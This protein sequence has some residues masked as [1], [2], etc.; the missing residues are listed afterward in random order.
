M[1]FPVLSSAT[2]ANALPPVP[3]PVQI[4]LLRHA[5]GSA[6]LLALLLPAS[7]AGAQA[8][9]APV[10]MVAETETLDGETLDI[11]GPRDATSNPHSLRAWVGQG[12]VRVALRVSDR[13]R[14]FAEDRTF[15]AAVP[16]EFEKLLA[17]ELNEAR[18]LLYTLT[19]D[20]LYEED[21]SDPS[22]PAEVDSLVFANEVPG[23][24]ATERVGDVKFWA[25]SDPADDRVFVVTT[26]RILVIREQ[27]G[28]LSFQ[29]AADELSST[30]RFVATDPADPINE[31]EVH[32]LER[33]RIV[34]DPGGT[35]YALVTADALGYRN[36]LPRPQPLVMLACDLDRAGGY[37]EPTFDRDPGVAKEFVYWNPLEDHPD[38]IDISK[39][40]ARA[41]MLYNLDTFV[42][43][44]GAY[45]LGACGVAQQVHLLRVT[46]AFTNGI[47][48]ISQVTLDD[49]R[50]VINVLAH[51]SDPRRFYGLS[52]HHMYAFKSGMPPVLGQTRGGN[53]GRGSFRDMAF[54]ELPGGRET[55]WTV[56]SDG[57]DSIGKVID[58]SE[59]V[60]PLPVADRFFGLY[61]CDGAVALPPDDVF[62]PTF[63]GVVRYSRQADDSF[64][65][66]P[67]SFSPA[68]VAG[69][70]KGRITEH[71]DIG[72]VAGVTRLFCATGRGDL[73]EFQLGANGNPRPA[74]SYVPDASLF[75]PPWAYSLTSANFSNDVVFLDLPPHGAYV[76]LDVSDA[77]VGNKA[78]ALVAFRWE[79][80]GSMARWESVAVASTPH[81]PGRGLASTID[82]ART[83]SGIFAF[84]DNNGGFSVFDL[85]RLA[86]SSPSIAFVQDVQTTVAGMPA[87]TT[88]IA[89]SNDRVFAAVREGDA[90]GGA[91]IR[92]YA[93]DEATG[94]VQLPQRAEYPDTIFQP[95]VPRFGRA[96]RMRFETLDPTTGNGRLYI[97][98]D[99]YLL[100][101]ERVGDSD[102]DHLT[103]T[104]YWASD[105]DGPLQDSR[106]YDFGDGPRLLV[107]K[108][109]EAFAIVPT[110]P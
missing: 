22:R 50:N 62:T 75:P 86:S 45:A 107:A 7:I 25:G 73:L 100:R 87:R 92:V 31:W 37:V 28:L 58:V 72:E 49:E 3:S 83:D 99:K 43:G 2:R 55:V 108:D 52:S 67:D 63:G 8:A 66:V 103:F 21:V 79:G 109:R 29:S 44:S 69:N 93:W 46:G 57:A 11:T 88:G 23:F 65:V 35:L 27:G 80:V 20:A 40:K 30:G 60:D 78:V 56:A 1:R 9:Q 106:L 24:D 96:F 68:Q 77:T 41:N 12:R 82:V 13:A 85:G 17:V 76:I 33:M 53:F 84:V 54:V 97:C 14:V 5:A 95:W 101:M 98:S 64:R 10:R 51:P 4:A 16:G 59:T 110:A 36:V 102:P 39:N 74:K 34:E 90:N 47:Q 89:H 38:G 105:Y 104:G 48:S 81:L 15:E 71:I 19:E 18:E 70:P 32:R 42:A 61:A 94:Q 91:V 6:R 26:K